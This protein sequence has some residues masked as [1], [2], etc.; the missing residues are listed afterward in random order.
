LWCFIPTDNDLLYIYTHTHTSDKVDV[1]IEDLA[2]DGEEHPVR[3]RVWV[4]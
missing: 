2:D 1:S 3:L 4:W